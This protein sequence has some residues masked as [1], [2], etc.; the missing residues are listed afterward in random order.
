MFALGLLP[1]G[2]SLP[3]AGPYLDLQVEPAPP[4]TWSVT[5][6]RT[7]S[8]DA[9]SHVKAHDDF[10]VFSFV[11]DWIRQRSGTEQPLGT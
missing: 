11:V 2:W 10:Q 9:L 4:G 7:R 6:L 8:R 5:Q 1:S 3:L